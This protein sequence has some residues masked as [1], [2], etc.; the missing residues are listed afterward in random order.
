VEF[1]SPKKRKIGGAASSFFSFFDQDN[2]RPGRDSGVLRF[3]AAGWVVKNST[4]AVS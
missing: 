4:T 1:Y 3:A 2:Q